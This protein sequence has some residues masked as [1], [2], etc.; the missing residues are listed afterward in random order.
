MNNYVVIGSGI[1]GCTAAY[2]LANQGNNVT[3]LERESIAGGKVLEYCC[4]ATDSCSRC[5]V[6]VAHTR[7]YETLSHPN[8][9]LLTGAE[10]TRYAE[11]KGRGVV[12]FER[13]NPSIDYRK[14]ELCGECVSACPEQCISMYKR[15]ELVQYV[16]DYSRCRLQNGK[17]CDA[18]VKACSAEAISGKTAA[19][20]DSVQGDGI[21]VA[22]GHTPFPAEEKPRY[23]YGRSENIITGAEAEARLSK[24]LDLGTARSIAFIQCVGSR[25]PVIGRN[26]CSAVCCSYALRLARIIKHRDTDID[27]SIYYIDIQNFDKEYNILR[28]EIED[29]GVQFKRGLPFRIDEQADGRLRCM[30][31]N[32][33]GEATVVHH[34]LVILSVGMGPDAEAGRM[35]DLLEMQQ[36]EFGFFVPGGAVAYTTGTCR[37]PQSIPESMAEAMSVASEMTEARHE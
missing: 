6:C 30:V 5:G 2:Y 25:D 28:K 26:Y 24:E 32:L 33:D 10:I 37:E 35:A 36:D 9:R 16:I 3:L 20:S 12:H 22:T 14:C 21:L 23:G 27:V 4:K 19:H 13:K 15:G 8:V 34:D 29:L 11:T 31:E 7:I 17:A 1:S 18:C